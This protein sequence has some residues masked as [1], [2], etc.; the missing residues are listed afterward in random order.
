M[1]LGL[2]IRICIIPN[3][4][5]NTHKIGVLLCILGIIHIH[6]TRPKHRC[7]KTKLWKILPQPTIFHFTT[8]LLILMHSLILNRNCVFS[9][10]LS[11][12]IFSSCY[13]MVNQSRDIN[14]KVKGTSIFI[15]DNVSKE[16]THRQPSYFVNIPWCSWW[17]QQFVFDA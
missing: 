7:L 13:N 3:I 6:K 4:H 9:L 17:I 1:C 2:V 15:N 10:W 14:C 11:T 16:K 8:L 12:N 5:I